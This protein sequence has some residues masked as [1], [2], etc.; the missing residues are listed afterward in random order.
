VEKTKRSWE[1]RIITYKII[2]CIIYSL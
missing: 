1:Y 2:I